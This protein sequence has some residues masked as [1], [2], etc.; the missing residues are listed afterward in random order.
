MSDQ[1]PPPPERPERTPDLRQLPGADPSTGVAPR[2]RIPRSTLIALVVI[3]V[4]TVIGAVN[5][6]SDDT[7][8][9]KRVSEQQ[10]D[11]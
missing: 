2:R 3:G 4:I 8:H 5:G 6:S 9:N 10:H 11:H 1:L 7:Q